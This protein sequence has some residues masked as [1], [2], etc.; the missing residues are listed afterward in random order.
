MW[1]SSANGGINIKTMQPL[2]G[3]AANGAL[4]TGE[5]EQEA[6]ITWG[7]LVGL[8]ERYLSQSDG[9]VSH[10]CNSCGLFATELPLEEG[11]Q[12]KRRV[13][14]SCKSRAE[15][16]GEVYTPSVSSAFMS[17][18]SLVVMLTMLSMGV[19]IRPQFGG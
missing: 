17:R 10:W 6:F 14:L 2:Q 11:E 16:N 8:H 19:A 4:K 9:G 18:A 13:C 1:E 12:K 15:G 7:M 5:M 3:A